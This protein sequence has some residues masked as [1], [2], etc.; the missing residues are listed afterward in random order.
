MLFK[1][2]IENNNCIEFHGTSIKRVDRYRYLGLILDENL[3][4]DAHI[5]SVKKKILPYI[6]AL[7][8]SRLMISEKTAKLIYYAYIFPHLIYMNPLWNNAT[9]G[10]LKSIKILQNKVCRIVLKKPFRYSSSL[11]YKTEFIPFENICKYETLITIFKIINNLIKHG[12]VIQ[13]NSEIHNHLTRNRGNFYVS[14]FKTSY[15]RNSFLVQ[16]LL[17]FNKLPEIIKN[18]TDLLK[19]KNGIKR[20]M[21]EV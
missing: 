5:D 9:I 14:F 1:N 11:L 16:G 19:F 20:M 17:E 8:R 7:S 21:I 2:T 3:N 18:T 15:G 4:W 13:T 12:L 6:F 10:R